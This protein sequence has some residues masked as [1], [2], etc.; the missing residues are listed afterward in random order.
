MEA[1]YHRQIMEQAL[2]Q[3]V[4]AGA[5]AAMLRANLAQ[6]RLVGLLRGE[7]HFDAG[8]TARARD[9]IEECR[10]LAAQASDAEQA[11][12]AFGRLT[13]G[14]QDFYAHSN[15]LQLWAD[16]RDG[17]GDLPAPAHV[18]G[19]EPDLLDHPQLRF[20]RVYYPLEVLWLFPVFQPWLKR[21][22]PRDSHACMNLDAPAAGPFF[23][24]ALEA[25]VQRTSA[26][27]DRTLALIGAHQGEAGQR[28]FLGR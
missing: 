13:H 17:Q 5:L 25:A 4:S 2:G 28:R 19:L 21:V 7:Y 3:R 14:A 20:A 23:P 1:E 15:Y 12:A 26:E 16:R 11:W 24:Y 22:L 10:A 6:D 8:R 27:F 18:Q 9:Y